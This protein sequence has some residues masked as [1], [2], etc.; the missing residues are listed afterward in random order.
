MKAWPPPSAL[1]WTKT[2]PSPTVL[3]CTKLYHITTF[4]LRGRSA[5]YCPAAVIPILTDNNKMITF[6]NVNH[7][8]NTHSSFPPRKVVRLLSVSFDDGCLFLMLTHAKVH[9]DYNI[10]IAK[11]WVL[12]PIFCFIYSSL[13]FLVSHPFSVKP[14]AVFL[15]GLQETL[16]CK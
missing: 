6:K 8:H 10:W 12:F 9:I 4:L 15:I 16:V 11:K 2:Q 1:S 5:D 7:Y 13:I 14:K 3:Y